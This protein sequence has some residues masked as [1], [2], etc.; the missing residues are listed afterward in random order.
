VSDKLG[1]TG[2]FPRGK[3]HETDQGALNIK[4]SQFRE[5]VHVDFGKPTA[6]V[7]FEPDQ[8][9]AFAALIVKHAMALKSLENLHG[10]QS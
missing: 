4:I 10:K 2:E 3:I 5:T 8:A 9:L 7:A 1:A 6:W